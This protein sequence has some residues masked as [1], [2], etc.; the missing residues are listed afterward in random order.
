MNDKI[1]WKNKAR[2]MTIISERRPKKLNENNTHIYK[3]SLRIITFIP[4]IITSA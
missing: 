3:N 4:L 2:K 1:K